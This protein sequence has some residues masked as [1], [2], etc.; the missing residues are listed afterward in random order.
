[1]PTYEIWWAY[2]YFGY[3]DKIL[4]FGIWIFLL[5]TRKS[6]LIF[7][8]FLQLWEESLHYPRK[9]SNVHVKTLTTDLVGRRWFWFSTLEQ[10]A[11]ADFLSGSIWWPGSSEETTALLVP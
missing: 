3:P 6:P 11:G 4:D 10:V 7:L 1:M 5:P 8:V 9:I 2:F